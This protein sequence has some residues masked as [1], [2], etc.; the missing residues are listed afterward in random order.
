[1]EIA[2]FALLFV[3]LLEIPVKTVSADDHERKK[4]NLGFPFCRHTRR[5]ELVL[6]RALCKT[7]FC[8]YRRHLP[9]K[10][11]CSGYCDSEAI[12]IHFP[13]IVSSADL[14]GI[15]RTRIQH[16]KDSL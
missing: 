13:I 1:M 7:A 15:A 9:Q 8:N 14:S 3:S 11:W 2:Q 5:L 16:T 12:M 4:I 6:Q 10:L